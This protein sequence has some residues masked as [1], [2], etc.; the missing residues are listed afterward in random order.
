M[1]FYCAK[2]GPLI[3]SAV[4]GRLRVFFAVFQ[5]TNLV[6]LGKRKCH[7]YWPDDSERYGAIKVM[8]TDTEELSDYTIRTFIIQVVRPAVFC[9]L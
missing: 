5:L 3:L 8:L 7:K 6:E 1:L 4:I 2:T 9:A